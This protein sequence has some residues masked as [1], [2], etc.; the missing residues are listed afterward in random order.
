MTPSPAGGGGGKDPVL[1]QLGLGF[2][3]QPGN[4]TP[5]LESEEGGPTRAK[6]WPK[7]WTQEAWGPRE[8]KDAT[9]GP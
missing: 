8:R 9:A 7:N 6:L 5:T 1:S 2:S 3:P 4:C